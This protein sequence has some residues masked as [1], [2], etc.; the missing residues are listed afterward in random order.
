[1]VTLMLLPQTVTAQYSENKF[2]Q[3]P[4]FGSSLFGRENSNGNL[5][6]SIGLGGTTQENP[7]PMGSGIAVLLVAGAGY[8]LLKRKE[9]KK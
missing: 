1:M 4:W 8:T 7:T 9:D 5:Y 3:Q 6:E 2:G